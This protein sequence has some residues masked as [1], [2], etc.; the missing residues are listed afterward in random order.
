MVLKKNSGRRFIVIDRKRYTEKI[1]NLLHTDSFIRLDNDSAK[2]IEGKIQ[3]FIRKIKS[4]FAKQEYSRL[5]PTRSSRG[6]FYDTAKQHTFKNGSS[7][8]YLPLRPNISYVRT[9]SYQLVKQ[10][11]DKTPFSINQFTIYSK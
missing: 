11:P 8:Y 3:R 6:K 9:A 1:F 5:Y 7:V 2:S 4:N 10:I